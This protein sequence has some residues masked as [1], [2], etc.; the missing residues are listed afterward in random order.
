VQ[1]FVGQSVRARRGA[2]ML[3]QQAH[4]NGPFS[5]LF[6]EAQVPRFRAHDTSRPAFREGPSRRAKWQLSGDEF[7]RAQDRNGTMQAIRALPLNGG[8]VLLSSR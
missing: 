2:H 8:N 5:S 3:E 1:A 7:S 4:Q 6:Q